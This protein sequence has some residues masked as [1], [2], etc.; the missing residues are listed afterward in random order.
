MKKIGILT[1]HRAVNYGAALQAFALQRKIKDL[2]H[3][4]EFLDYGITGD[5]GAGDFRKVRGIADKLADHVLVSPKHYRNTAK[6]IHNALV[7]KI[8][9]RFFGMSTAV[10]RGAFRAFGRNY[11]NISKKSFLSAD[12][13]STVEDDYDGFITGSDQVW[14][15]LITQNNLVYFL[16][17]IRNNNKKISYAPSFGSGDISDEF[18]DKIAGELQNIPYLSVREQ[19]GAR[20]IKNISNREAF[21]TVDPTLLLNLEQWKEIIPENGI[22]EPYIFCYAFF[23]NPEVRRVCKYLSNITGFRIV[24]LSLYQR[25]YQRTKEYLD[26][27]TLYVNESGP[28]EF[29]SYLNKASVVVT[30]SYHGILFSINF[31]KNF[32]VVPFEMYIDRILDVLD[33]YGLKER[34]LKAG[35]DVPAQDDINVDYNL[36]DPIYERE[37][38][39]SIDYLKKSLNSI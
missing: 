31:K 30:N 3:Q 17:F 34:A 8:E 16:N 22:D 24:R 36:V 10:R 20:I 23:D 25:N 38:N 4:A 11:L 21:V 7:K 28:L 39:L 2:G 27:S 29:L 15:P 5:E 18:K 1:F 37:K 12:E 6:K 19:S 26:R 32:F 13:L 33:I 9:G 35:D 14:N